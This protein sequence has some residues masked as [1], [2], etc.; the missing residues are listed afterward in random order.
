MNCLI[1]A[2]FLEDIQAE[3]ELVQQFG[4]A[5]RYCEAEGPWQEGGLTS[6]RLSSLS[7]SIR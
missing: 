6:V 1:A 7:L 2:R 5:F 3:V 4:T